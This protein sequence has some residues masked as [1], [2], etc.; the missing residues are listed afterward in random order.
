[1]ADPV[2][3]SEGPFFLWF[4]ETGICL[5]LLLKAILFSIVF[6]GIGGAVAPL[7]FV[8]MILGMFPNILP[9]VFSMAVTL[10]LL[11]LLPFNALLNLIIVL[12]RKAPNYDGGIYQ[13]VKWVEKRRLYDPFYDLSKVA[14]I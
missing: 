9:S 8:G 10:P 5:G 13:A 4:K 1:M 6:L 12:C 11:L 2:N 3:D 7:I 14:K